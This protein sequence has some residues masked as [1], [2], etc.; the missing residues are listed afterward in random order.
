MSWWNCAEIRRFHHLRCYKPGKW[1]VNNGI[2]YQPQL[3]SLPDFWKINRR[4]N[5]SCCNCSMLTVGL[6]SSP[7]EKPTR[8]YMS[9]CYEN[10]RFVWPRYIKKLR[11]LNAYS[12]VLRIQIL[13][14]VHIPGAPMTSIFEGQPKPKQSLFPPTK[15]GVICICFSNI[16]LYI[17]ISTSFFHLADIF[18][19]NHEVSIVRLPGA[20]CFG[21]CGFDSWESPK[22]KLL[23]NP[24]SHQTWVYGS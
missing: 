13:Y 14:I 6:S 10:C 8:L 5:K 21:G 19:A 12:N 11:N 1:H 9:L 7:I 18:P 2:S 20:S 3:V 22:Q 23:G 15:T 24:D 17:Y 4:S 16:I